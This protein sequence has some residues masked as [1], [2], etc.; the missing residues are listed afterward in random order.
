MTKALTL[1]AVLALLLAAS[2][3][4][5]QEYETYT[6]PDL[7]APLPGAAPIDTWNWS[8]LGTRPLRA[9]HAPT[10][11]FER[12][13]RSTVYDVYS[14][15]DAPALYEPE[16]FAVE[17]AITDSAERWKQTMRQMR[18]DWALEDER[19]HRLRERQRQ[20]AEDSH[21]NALRV[22]A[23]YNRGCF[24]ELGGRSSRQR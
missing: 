11:I 17:P 15:T 14:P 9:P 12:M 20:A 2:P 6:P 1:P 23:Q 3:L 19:F 18:Q 22:C 7:F 16:P 13:P 10:T 8:A 24:N 21:L 5:A 4:A